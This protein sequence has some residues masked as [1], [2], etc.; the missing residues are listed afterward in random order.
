MKGLNTATSSGLDD[1]RERD[2]PLGSALAAA[3]MAATTVPAATRHV[4]QLERRET[5]LIK[6]RLAAMPTELHDA[7]V[8]Y[9]TH[10]Y[11]GLI[12]QALGVVNCFQDSVFW[13]V[14]VGTSLWA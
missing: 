11:R 9:K 5:V 7:V 4:A 13:C 6:K 3:S 8:A 14:N 12:D 10:A 2:A 1:A